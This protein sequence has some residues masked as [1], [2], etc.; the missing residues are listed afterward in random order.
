MV[1]RSVP[2]SSRWEANAWRSECG[3]ISLVL[4][5]LGRY[6]HRVAIANNRLIDFVDG[7]VTFRWKDYRHQSRQ[8]VM[9][10]PGEEFVRR[11]LLHVLP[12]GF[13][14]IRHYG[15]ALSRSFDLAI[16]QHASG[17]DMALRLAAGDVLLGGT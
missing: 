12:P 3:V 8:K 1:R 2:A 17:R 10:L 5:Y 7:E 11:F 6:T 13:Q 9:R 4:E 15:P 16:L 14:R